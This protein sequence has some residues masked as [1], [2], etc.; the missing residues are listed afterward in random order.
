M[1]TRRRTVRDRDYARLLSI[2]TALREFDKWSADRAADCGL[3]S[4]QHQLLLAV[5][6]H[7]AAHPTAG[8]PAIGDVARYLLVQ[9]HAAVELVDRTA[10]LGLVER[11]RDGNDQRVMRLR[12]TPEGAAKLEDLSAT[13]IAELTAL[14]E[15]LD[16]LVGEL[17][18]P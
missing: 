17:P 14:R 13:H 1:G 11:V 16:R 12:L 9:H 4:R 18:K 8:P 2:R 3:T 10:A 15:L 7:E 6:G 5:R